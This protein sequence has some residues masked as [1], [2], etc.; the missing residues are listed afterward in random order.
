MRRRLEAARDELVSAGDLEFE[1]LRDDA[2]ALERPD[3]D[4]APLTEM[5]QVIA[6]KRNRERSERLARI[7]A[8]LRR[9]EADPDD[10]GLCEACEEEIAPRRLEV[11]P[12]ARFCVACQAKQ[13]P[14][15]G[16]AR[17]SL[18]DYE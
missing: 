11:M 8:A 15:R 13:D 4:A 16:G 18:T 17:R 5:N 3:E 2:D 10:F 6:S 12:W 14:E 7:Q 9:L 1:P